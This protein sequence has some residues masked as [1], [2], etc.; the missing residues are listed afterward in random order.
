MIMTLAC[1]TVDLGII[2][3]I[4]NGNDFCNYYF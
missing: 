4:L 1:A 3:L 2:T